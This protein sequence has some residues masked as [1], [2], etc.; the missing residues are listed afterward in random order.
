[1][2]CCFLCARVHDSIGSGV[3]GQGYFVFSKQECLSSDAAP[4]RGR[5]EPEYLLLGLDRCPHTGA[6]HMQGYAFRSTGRLRNE[7]HIMQP[8]LHVIEERTMEL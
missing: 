7:L 2:I 6:L 1:M 5:G 8:L 4:V 3:D